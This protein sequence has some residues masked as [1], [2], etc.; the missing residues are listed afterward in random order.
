MK[1]NGQLEWFWKDGKR[2]YMDL[3]KKPQQEVVARAT[4]FVEDNS[5]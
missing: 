1:Q 5:D 4:E 2:E 3:I